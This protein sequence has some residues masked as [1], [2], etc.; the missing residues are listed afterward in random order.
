MCP[1]PAHLQPGGLLGGRDGGTLFWLLLLEPWRYLGKAP[2]TG[3]SFRGSTG[4]RWVVSCRVGVMGTSRTRG[5]GT[6]AG[7]VI[8][9]GSQ[10]HGPGGR[11]W[12]SRGTAPF[13]G[14]EGVHHRVS[15]LGR[16]WL[17]ALA[18]WQDKPWGMAG[19]TPSFRWVR[20]R[21][22]EVGDSLGHPVLSIP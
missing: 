10:C 20:V 7:G 19:W 11:R 13:G 8:S 2:G 4:M 18:R 21:Q 14:E 1:P 9:G 17:S 5:E 12:G 3:K 22:Q 16:G 15:L 6:K